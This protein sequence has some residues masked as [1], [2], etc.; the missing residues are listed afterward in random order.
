[1]SRFVTQSYLRRLGFPLRGECGNE[2]SFDGL[3]CFALGSVWFVLWVVTD[4][5]M[6]NVMG[7]RI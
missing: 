5:L 3:L 1:M 6:L 2:P 7:Q 4:A